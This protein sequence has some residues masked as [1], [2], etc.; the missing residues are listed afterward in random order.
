MQVSFN[1]LERLAERD[2]NE[3]E[4]AL[5]A[6][7]RCGRYLFGPQA[8]RLEQ[9]ISSRLG[10]DP[11]HVV[12]CGSGTDALLLSLL[13]A[14]IRA[15][16]EVVVPV[17]TAIPTAA[18]VV[19][20]GAKP[21]FCDVNPQT[22]LMGADEIEAVITP[23]TRAIIPVHLHGNVVNTPEIRQTFPDL[24]L[25]EDV[26]QAQGAYWAGKPA[27]SFGDYAAFS[28]Y[29]TKNLGALGDGGCLVTSRE[30]NAERARALAFYGQPVRGEAVIPRGTNSR[31]DEL[32]A[33]T[34]NLRIARLAEDILTKQKL[35]EMYL[36]GLAGL[37]LL[38]QRVDPRATPAWN[39]FCVQ[40][41]T[42][43]ERDELRAHL[44]ARGVATLIHYSKPLHQQPAFAGGPK[45][46]PAAEHLSRTILSLPFGA[47]HTKEEI[48]Q[49]CGV[50]AEFFRASRFRASIK[51]DRRD[52]SRRSL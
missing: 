24:T 27:G 4:K 26:A 31:L 12:S 8:R 46:F 14:G 39:L 43:H 11:G 51:K 49:V 30:A 25:I 34:L 2:G 44:E 10:V 41:N 22:W 5:M 6:V 48:S 35:R 23:R 38:F 28:F 47:C 7:A 3:L 19:L 20:A 36:K 16:D 42:P 18:A 32:Q 1:H 50:A 40:T 9:N 21:V 13:A 33:A 37:P 29:P 17:N 45:S 52:L 15:G